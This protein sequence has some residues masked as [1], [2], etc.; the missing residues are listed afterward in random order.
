[1]TPRTFTA[2]LRLS[3]AELAVLQSALT[4]LSLVNRQ[5][6]AEYSS[7]RVSAAPD[8]VAPNASY[9]QHLDS[10]IAADEAQAA[11]A[12]ALFTKFVRAE[13]RVR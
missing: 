11:A 8:G 5:R 12:D 1:M 6:I 4:V 3:L 7:S 10:F 13:N 9:Y 2:T